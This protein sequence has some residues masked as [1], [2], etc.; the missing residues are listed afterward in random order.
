VIFVRDRTDLAD[1]SLI[2]E[3]PRARLASSFSILINCPACDERE[4]KRLEERLRPICFPQRMLARFSARNCAP[5]W[6]TVVKLGLRASVCEIP[7][8]ATR[9]H[10]SR[11]G[12]RSCISWKW[13]THRCFLLFLEF[14]FPAFFYS[15]VR[16]QD[17][18]QDDRT[19]T[20]RPRDI[21]LTDSLSERE[22][23]SSRIR[24][25]ANP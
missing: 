2:K 16:F 9:F 18:R 5:L 12:I 3:H 17:D 24:S 4:E 1:T 15:T 8:I 21:L 20:I 23:R 11:M 13:K 22:Q 7:T 19:W 14:P 25:K 10:Q 6:R